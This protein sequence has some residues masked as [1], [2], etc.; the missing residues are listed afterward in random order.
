MV[1]KQQ[2]T[3]KPKNMSWISMLKCWNGEFVFAE[4]F[5]KLQNIKNWSE[6]KYV[7]LNSSWWLDDTRKHEVEK[8]NKIYNLFNTNALLRL[9]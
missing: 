2:V 1:N 5:P 3:S 9:R 6:M 8:S 4:H 7:A